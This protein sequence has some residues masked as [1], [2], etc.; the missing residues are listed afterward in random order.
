MGALAAA[1]FA[2]MLITG[3]FSVYALR[4]RSEAIAQRGEAEG[5]IEFMLGDLRKKLEPVGRLDVMD[6]VGERALKYYSAQDAGALDADSL[7]RRARALHLIGEVDDLRG[8]L[9]HALDVFEQ[10]ARSTSEL[11][12]RAPNDGQR[13]FDHAQSMYWV[14]Y[15]AWQRGDNAIAEKGFNEYRALADRLVAL[16]SGECGLAGR[17]RVREQQP[18]HVAGRPAASRTKRRPRS[19][20]REKVDAALVRTS[21][22]VDRQLGLAQDNS[23][24]AT[25][26][27]KQGRLDAATASLGSEVAIYESILAGDAHNAQA[28]QSLFV[29]EQSLGRLALA[30]G[31]VD[32]ASRHLKSAI[33][34]S[35]ALRSLDPSNMLWVELAAAARANEADR[36]LQT[37]NVDAARAETTRVGELAKILVA[38]DATNVAWQVT[39]TDRHLLLAA[40]LEQARGDRPAALEKTRALIDSLQKLRAEHASEQRIIEMLADAERLEGELLD[41]TGRSG[42]AAEAWQ[43]VV[44]LLSSD[45]GSRDPHLK[46]TLAWAYFRLGQDDALRAL[47]K[48]LDHIGYRHPDYVELVARMRRP[49]GNA[50]AT[51]VAESLHTP[52]PSH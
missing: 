28:H 25:V 41:A 9:D 19:S 32:E 5:L 2:G 51:T 48:D 36:L 31:D 33:E 46:T 18:R 50:A 37:G 3:G 43:R 27:E 12:A 17:S 35:E 24:L 11:L 44:E 22:S 6:S 8:N 15:I 7:G 47:T 14:G 23:W 20:A 4:A 21:P 34:G 29:A 42:D 16:D 10:A 45:A 40:R 52:L 38:H 26:A 30:R 39:V 13:I 1:S 49:R